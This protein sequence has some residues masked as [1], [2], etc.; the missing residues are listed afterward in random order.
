M[1]GNI[2]RSNYEKLYQ[3]IPDLND[4]GA[5]NLQER[6]MRLSAPR[7]PDLHV[8]LQEKNPQLIRLVLS[9]NFED[10]G[11][12]VKDSEIHIRVLRE[13]ARRRH[14]SR[15]S[16]HGIPPVHSCRSELLHCSA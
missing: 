7:Y 11:E 9:H 3:L 12:V 1:Q 14:V 2:Y 15:R 6:Y 13:N 4:I 16:S 8:D 10:K 5:V